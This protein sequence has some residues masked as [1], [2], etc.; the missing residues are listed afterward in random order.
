MYT[1]ALEILQRAYGPDATFRDG[2]WDAIESVLRGDKTLVVQQTGWGKSVVY[3]IATKLRRLAGNGPTLL[4]SPLLSLA[5]NQ[6]QSALRFGLTAIGLNSSDAANRQAHLTAIKQNQVD[7]ILITPEQLA[8]ETRFKTLLDTM[9][10]GVGLFV[11]DEAHCISDWGHDFRPDYRRIIDVLS[12]V[13]KIT[14]VLATTA[15][16]NARVIKDIANQIG[17]V[18]V[19]RGPL[20]RKSLQIQILPTA[21]PAHRLA[22]LN[23][24]VSSMPGTGIIY[25]LTGRDCTQVANWLSKKGIDARAYTGRMDNAERESLEAGLLQNTFKCLVSTVALGMGFDKPDLGFVIHYQRPGN[26]VA[27]YQQIGRAGRNIE[28]AYAVLLNDDEDD[29]IQEYFIQSAFPTTK[30]MTKVVE[31]IDTAENGLTKEEI[32][33]MV[34]MSDRRIE[35]CIRY[36]LVEKTIKEQADRSYTRTLNPWQPNTEH[37]A[38][39]SA[40]RRQELARMH[41]YTTDSGCSMQFIATELDDENPQPCGRC[42]NCL[43][44]KFFSEDINDADATEASVFLS[45]TSLSIQ[46][47]IEWPALMFGNDTKSIPLEFR[48]NPGLAMALSHHR[49]GMQVVHDKEVNQTF[50]EQ[51]VKDAATQLKVWM[52]AKI[53][54][55][56]IV[57][58]PS[59]RSP[60]LVPK[61]AEDLAAILGID[62]YDLITKKTPGKRQQQLRNN[63]LLC[64]NALDSFE[65]PWNCSGLDII[66]VDDFVDTRWTLTVCAYLLLK[67]GAVAVTPY[68]LADLKSI[69]D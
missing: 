6:I 4:I 29:R 13:S 38:A 34:N 45:R 7:I 20:S 55:K 26:L 68:V 23:K 25:C 27:Y 47:R 17:N 18:R 37:A 31:V 54:K 62:F 36:L 46:P 32:L 66:L 1:T 48:F 33:S 16:A 64:K 10:P 51:L 11:I 52:G 61:L 59:L 41:A 24:H 58:V 9:R 50:D 15:T 57:P 8:H 35:N 12:I 19:L 39:I 14:P 49:N 65:V 40:L 67:E 42:S 69:S 2:Q 60:S 53:R 3:F 28:N 22:W 5:R 30:E 44:T 43:A 21:D 63:F 56:C